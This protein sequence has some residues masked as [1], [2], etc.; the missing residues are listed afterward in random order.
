M[1]DIQSNE[2]RAAEDHIHI[3]TSGRFDTLF[4][5]EV[6]HLRQADVS[7]FSIGIGNVDIR[8]L[9]RISS[10]AKQPSY[11]WTARDMNTYPAE[12][13]RFYNT[14]CLG[15]PG[16]DNAVLPPVTPPPRTPTRL[17]TLRE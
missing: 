6:E 2:R 13:E 7:I 5:T 16:P 11:F 3:F 10:L 8:Q 9:A 12:A 17:Y 4:D 14:V 1:F 15:A